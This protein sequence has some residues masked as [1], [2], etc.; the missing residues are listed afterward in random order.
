MCW[1]TSLRNAIN[2]KG[3][4]EVRFI[5]EL[6]D[7]KN[8]FSQ[9]CANEIQKIVEQKKGPINKHTQCTQRTIHIQKSKTNECVKNMGQNELVQIY[10]AK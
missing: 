1:N 10:G 5:L 6:G 3:A 8:P 7:T 9:F 4:E 2:V